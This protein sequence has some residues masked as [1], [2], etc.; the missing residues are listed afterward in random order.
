MELIEKFNFNKDAEILIYGYGKVGQDLHLRL[1]E[2]GYRVNGIIDK[3]AKRFTSVDNCIFIKP[4]ELD[5][6]STT[7]IIILTL[8]N[9]LEHERVVKMLLTKGANKIVYL[10]RSRPETYQACF[11]IY[12]QL[13]C[14][15]RIIDFEFPLTTVGFEPEHKFYYREAA[16]SVIVEVPMS[17]LFTDAESQIWHGINITA[18]R[19]YNALYDVLLN[20]KCESPKDFKTYCDILC[21]SNR[22]LDAYLQ[23]RFLLYQ[24][25]QGEYMNHG[26]SFFRNAPS[27][28][29]WNQK[30]GYFNLVD[31]LH[32]ASFLINNQVHTI[33]IRITKE[34]YELW[35]NSSIEKKCSEYFE[36]QNIGNT[37]TPIYH[38]AFCDIDYFAEKGGSLTASALYQYFTNNT[39]TDMSVL[40]INSN[41]SFFSQIFAR[42]GV[43]KI[44]S[45]ES[46]EELFGLAELL[47]QLHYID[48]I[49]MHNDN[50]ED[51]EIQKNYDVVIMANDLLPDYHTGNTGKELLQKIDSLSSKYFI[52]RSLM[53]NDEERRYVLNKSSFKSYHRLN[54]EI[55]EGK[56]SEVGVFEK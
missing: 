35:Y 2:Q 50:V 32:R 9:I 28:A 54:I 41:L 10:N 4:E 22:T 17:L 33:P 20:G 5:T 38:P 14:G 21:G 44:V 12:N 19:E 45:A 1:V 23:D 29:K 37:F 51:L 6:G 56:L 18:C 25:M 48:T 49:D 30:R 15:N 55:I 52:S 7:H 16:E 39:E 13:V 34:D 46:R 11:R 27:T 3:N 8:Q 24:M 42:M 40:D 26:L 36:E 53:E 47:N 31:G 43:K